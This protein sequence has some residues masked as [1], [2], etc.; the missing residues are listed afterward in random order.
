LPMVMITDWRPFTFI[1]FFFSSFFFLFSV[2]FY[3]SLLFFFSFYFFFPSFFIFCLNLS[4]FLLYEELAPNKL[5]REIVLDKLCIFFSKD[6]RQQLLMC[7]GYVIHIIYYVKSCY[8]SYVEK[9]SWTS[10]SID[11][12]DQKLDF[13]GYTE[14]LWL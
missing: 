5:H 10:F 11:S 12:Y 7:I 9:L 1:T 6:V 13:K 8:K 4:N 3:F 14:K 2:I